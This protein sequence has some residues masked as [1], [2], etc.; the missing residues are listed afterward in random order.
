VQ[1]WRACDFCEVQ[2]AAETRRAATPAGAHSR[3]PAARAPANTSARQTGPTQ[4]AGTSS[5]QAGAAAASAGARRTA[6]SGTCTAPRLAPSCSAEHS[7][8]QASCTPA[9]DGQEGGDMNTPP[10]HVAPVHVHSQWC[11]Q[12]RSLP[13]LAVSWPRLSLGAH[14]QTCL[15]SWPGLSPRCM[16]PAARPTRMQAAPRLRPA[17]GPPGAGRPGGRGSA[18]RSQPPR[19]AAGTAGAP[20]T[21]CSPLAG[22]CAA[23]GPGAQPP[24]APATYTQ[25]REARCMCR[26]ATLVEGGSGPEG[27]ARRSCH[28]LRHTEPR[29]G[30]K[31]AALR[32]RAR[33]RAAQTVSRWWVRG[34]PRCA[35]APWAC[36]AQTC[37]GRR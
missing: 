29:Q 13:R 23:A 12:R 19:A 6:T 7:G 26:P 4:P 5:T 21:A 8:W 24:R 36:A 9:C 18:C 32:R 14:K 3:R 27:Q 10:R 11:C 31:L 25:G 30:A 2:R 15:P 20:P 16:R 34:L 17:P 28:A 1:G 37:P 33:P 35:R 22:P